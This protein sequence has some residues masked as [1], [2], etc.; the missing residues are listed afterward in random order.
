MENNQVE[1]FRLTGEEVAAI[2]PKTF[3]IFAEPFYEEMTDINNPELK[4]KKLVIPVELANKTKVEWIANKTSQKTI[5][6]AR[7]RD[8]KAWIGYKG[9]FVTNEQKVGNAVKQVIYLK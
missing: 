4:K 1:G 8:L 6:G 7:G 5:I 2:E 3:T 9:T